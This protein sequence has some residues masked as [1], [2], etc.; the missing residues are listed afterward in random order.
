[1]LFTPDTIG[2]L[3]AFL[4]ASLSFS[5]L[6]YL[7]HFVPS[8]PSA[9]LAGTEMRTLFLKMLAFSN[10][11]RCIS[12]LVDILVRHQVKQA[13]LSESWKTWVRDVFMDLPTLMFMTAYS[14]V[15]L[16][17]AQVYYAAVLV[18]FPLLKF[19]FI[20]V[21]ISSYTLFF[22]ILLITLH[23]E[24][25]TQVRA[26]LLI[27]VSTLFIVCSCL[28]FNFGVKIA[29]HLSER[30]SI[31]L[32]RR[33]II[34]RIVVLTASVPFILAIR[35]FYG[36]LVAFNIVEAAPKNISRLVWD[37]G[38]CLSTELLPSLLCVF[39]FWP[40]SGSTAQEQLSPQFSSILSSESM[41]IHDIQSPLMENP[42]W[43][44]EQV[45]GRRQ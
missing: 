5:L 25:W 9:A 31:A 35:G 20:F 12:I 29:G 23:M 4:F 43:V 28:L 39:T 6:F 3:A 34:R 37:V 24:A 10:G 22:V 26:Y 8:K 2:Y 40:A 17:W 41:L 7:K 32:S 13:A 38:V 36:F 16:F 42:V 45:E 21:N 33:H 30:R 15:I 19:I 18:Q 1:M 44:E 27:L 14:V 11:L